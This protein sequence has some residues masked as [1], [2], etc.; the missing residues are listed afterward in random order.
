MLD[1]IKELKTK[2]EQVF[3][4]KGILDSTKS[5]DGLEVAISNAKLLCN[6]L[7]SFYKEDKSAYFP[8]SLTEQIENY[9]RDGNAQL[10]ALL[11]KDQSQNQQLQQNLDRLYALCLQSGILSFGFDSKELDKI[12]DNTKR[13][14]QSLEGKLIE[15]KNNI[16]KSNNEAQRLLQDWIKQLDDISKAENTKIS[17]KSTSAIA[18]I[19]KLTQGF[20]K[21]IDNNNKV[22]DSN[23]KITNELKETVTQYEQVSKEKSESV[24]KLLNTAMA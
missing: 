16:D 9:V 18:E 15:I 23:V 14:T 10:S 1:Q 17:D 24:E 7:I 11:A 3:K 19:D 6:E 13:E 5:I 12:I 21:S 4:N 20:Q 22:L 2:V 8:R